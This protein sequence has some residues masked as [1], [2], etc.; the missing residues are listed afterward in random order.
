MEIEFEATFIN[1]DKDVARE[2]LKMAG[3][4]LVRPEYMQRRTVFNLPIG[5]EIDGGWLRVRDEGDKITMSLKIVD[6][7]KIENQKEICLEIKDYKTAVDFLETLGCEKKA[8]QESKRELWK[9]GSIEITIDEWPF[10]EPFVEIEGRSEQ[11]V[12]SISEKLGFDYKDAKFCSVDHLYKLKYN[13]E[14]FIIN[15]ETPEI[16]FFGK[17]PFID[18]LI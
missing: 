15:N 6:G 7:Q 11:E 14:E 17:N 5:H 18:N 3:A 1:Q 2:K 4:V 12:K 13:I 10:L 8:F 9:I 16:T